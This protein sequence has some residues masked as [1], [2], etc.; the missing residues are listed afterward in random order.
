[1]GS[2]TKDRI[3]LH[4]TL[5]RNAFTNAIICT[6]TF[7]PQFFEEYCL[8]KFDSLRRNGN[9]TVILDHRTYQRAILASEHNRPRLA[10]LRYLLHPAAPAGVF[11][12]KLVL[13]ASP[14]RGRLVIGSANFTRPGIT[15]N[16]ELVGAFDFELDKNEAALPLFAQAVAFLERMAERW[17]SE[18]LDSNLAAL[19]RDAEWLTTVPAANDDVV[20]LD[21]LSRP[22]LDQLKERIVPPVSRLSVVSR[23]FDETPSLLTR[24][25]KI[26]DPA[27]ICIYTQNGTTTMTPAWIDACDQLDRD[28][29]IYL[30]PYGDGDSPQDLHAKALLIEDAEGALLA[31]GS[32]NFTTPALGRTAD[33]GNVELLLAVRLPAAKPSAE[34]LFAPLE[35]LKCL[36]DPAELRRRVDDDNDDDDL[37]PHGL[38][39][40]EAILT[41]DVLRLSATLPEGIAGAVAEL[42]FLDGATA[43]YA[44]HRSEDVL[45][46]GAISGADL[47]RLGDASSL[48]RFRAGELV[49]N[50]VLVTNLQDV[51]TGGST[52][53][54]RHLREAQESARRYFLVHH[55]LAEVGDR[56]ALIQFY[57]LCNIEVT[58]APLPPVLRGGRGPADLMTGMRS[59]GERNLVLSR[60]L[61]A[62]ATGFVDRHLRRLERHVTHG[63]IGGAS[64]FAHIFLAT[65]DVI[66]MQMARITDGL[67]ALAEPIHT[68]HWGHIRGQINVYYRALAALSGCLDRYVGYLL[69]RYPRQEVLDHLD[70]E[71]QQQMHK[72]VRVLL[73]AR[74]TIEQTRATKLQFKVGIQARL[75]PGWFDC[76][77]SEDRWRPYER[78]VRRQLKCLEGM[79]R[80]G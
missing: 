65:V 72:H 69:D 6:Y 23:F 46:T 8:D 24:T 74:R 10:N 52:R 42:R 62:A 78:E 76:V 17:P 29:T 51:R 38:V 64:N 80:A 31:Y 41:G 70:P 45:R 21:N 75:G 1:M 16:A 73:G 27:T 58:N 34:A 11:H 2:P 36:S 7:N 13:L 53:R 9:I 20:L 56:D 40:G 54:G 66:R 33:S 37:E 39:L 68:H 28:A 5:Q 22:L 79:R 25:T 35:G 67:T 26:L 44:V 57:D 55:E 61:H 50:F 60:S 43:H 63:E 77:M 48:V 47:R 12:S 32:A 18:S 14:K 19:R 71:S 30:C 59:L 15:S 4:E 49:S 3:D